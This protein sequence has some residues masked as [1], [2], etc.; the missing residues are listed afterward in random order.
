MF[1]KLKLETILIPFMLLI[2][3]SGIGLIGLSF[4]AYSKLSENKNIDNCV[5][6]SI[7]NKLRLS[8]SIGTVLVSIFIGYFLCVFRKD[9]KCNFG[10]NSTV[11]MYVLMF[12]LTVLGISMFI[13]SSSINKDLNSGKCKISLGN[14]ESVI[15]WISLVQ[16]ILPI[17]YVIIS[18]NILKS[19]NNKAQKLMKDKIDKEDDIDSHLSKTFKLNSKRTE[20]NKRRKARYQ[21]RIAEEKEK[22]S[23]LQEK[24]EKLEEK[25]Q[26]NTIYD[27]QE[28]DLNESIKKLES[29]LNS[30][31]NDSSSISNSSVDNSSIDN[32]SVYNSSVDN[33]SVD[34]SLWGN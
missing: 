33:Y 7:K 30:I 25:N 12:I 27:K 5:T 15:K 9:C 19:K 8:I 31:S 32:Y 13:L 10:D 3:V 2:L 26:R 6:D 4:D 21:R 14:F 1:D 20:T 28:K 24:I 16:I 17:I 22:L 29:N 11:K 34:N 23:T 18:Y